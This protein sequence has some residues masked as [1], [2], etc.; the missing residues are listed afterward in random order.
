VLCPADGDGPISERCR[1][2]ARLAYGLAAVGERPAN[3]PVTIGAVLAVV[4]LVDVVIGAC[5]VAAITA[6]DEGSM[7][8]GAGV[9]AV[10]ALLV[11]SLVVAAYSSPA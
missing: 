10:L 1:I 2:A 9:V 5:V 8:A 4:V 11:L 6:D 3:R 7:A